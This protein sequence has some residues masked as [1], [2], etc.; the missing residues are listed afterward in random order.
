MTLVNHQ[1]I[2]AVVTAVARI[3]SQVDAAG[4]TGFIDQIKHP[5][6]WSR[7]VSPPQ[8]GDYLHAVVLDDSR[9]P[10]RLSALQSD[11]EIA[12]VLSERQ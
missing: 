9:T 5:S 7:D 6:W 4:I 1:E 11:I 12:R 8:V 3:G 10:P 2:N